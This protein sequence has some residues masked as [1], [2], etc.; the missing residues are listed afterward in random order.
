MGVGLCRWGGVI[1]RRR[2]STVTPVINKAKDMF[3][4]LEHVFRADLHLNVNSQ[5]NQKCLRIRF[6][7]R[8]QRTKIGRIKRNIVH[9]KARLIQKKCKA[10]PLL[11]GTFISV[12]GP[13]D[14]TGFIYTRGAQI[15]VWDALIDERGFYWSCEDV[16]GYV[17]GIRLSGTVRRRFL[18]A[19]PLPEVVS[20]FD[21]VECQRRLHAVRRGGEG[22]LEEHMC[23]PNICLIFDCQIYTQVYFALKSKR[24]NSFVSLTLK[25]LS[26]IE[27]HI[28]DRSQTGLAM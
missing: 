4:C 5:A 19:H 10:Y 24:A 23:V 28:S 1:G 9:L 21:G 25:R 17:I 27:R 7:M 13:T 12:V 15:R 11:L 2:R 3:I 20:I 18:T 26:L 14:H 22:F 16:E 6:L 8:N